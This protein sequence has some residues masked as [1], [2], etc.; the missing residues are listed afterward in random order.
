[1]S[2]NISLP[3][4]LFVVSFKI[5]E[6]T[7]KNGLALIVNKKKVTVNMHLNNIKDLYWPFLCLQNKQQQIFPT[8]LIFW[9]P[10]NIVLLS[11]NQKH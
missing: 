7:F 5:L 3:S 4:D 1:M 11:E 8:I 10:Y 6:I 2:M 9:R